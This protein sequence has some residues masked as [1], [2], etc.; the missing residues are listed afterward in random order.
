MP[1]LWDDE[2]VDR[3]KQMVANGDR[4][5]Q[6]AKEFGCS[7]NA[8]IGAMLRKSIK[9]HY[10]RGNNGRPKSRPKPVLQK[11]R[12][13]AHFNFR[14]AVPKEPAKSIAVTL[15]PKL[16]LDSPRIE[17]VVRCSIFELTDRK[18]K[19]PIGTVGQAGFGFCGLDKPSDSD[20]PYCSEHQARSTPRE[21][22]DDEGQNC[23]K[24]T[25][26]KNGQ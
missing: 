15:P 7:R 3:L 16:P 2:T 5:R 12:P 14:S 4:T 8:V 9:S 11:P 21:V 13:K 24:A 10:G 6:I 18:C 23:D 20:S 1:M 25:Q 22:H 17:D 26:D 19:W